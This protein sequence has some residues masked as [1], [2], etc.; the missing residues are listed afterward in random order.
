MNSD[1]P[2]RLVAPE[3]QDGESQDLSLRPTRLS[4]YI[5]QSTVKENLRVF[6]HAARKRGQALDHVLLSGPPGLGKT[7]L[8]NIFANELAVPLR[9]SSGPVVERQG[10]L[11]AIL[12][13]LEPGSVLFL[14]EIHRMNRVVEEVLYSAMEDFT[15]DILIGEGP[16]ARTVKLDLPRFTLVGAT[17]RAGLLSAPLRDR[18]GIQCRLEYYTPE[19]LKLIVIRAAA[20]LEIEIVEEAAMELATR[21]RGT[22]RIANRMLRRCRDFADLE[23]GGVITL[24][25]VQKSLARM[26]ID[27]L[28]LD[29][30]DCHILRTIIEKYDGGPVGLNTLSAAVSEEQDTLE[31]VY[32]PFLL[33]QGFLQRT[34]RGRMVT[35]Q[36]YEHLGMNIRSEDQLPLFSN[37]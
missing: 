36:A 2:D 21:S 24:P 4:E 31:E 6:I 3:I 34:P 30:M 18:F 33:M 25:L 16:A 26:G 29:Q 19:E 17:T 37:R 9:S 10:D 14:D 22:P 15:L 5:A 13:N 1:N 32:E 12:T 23:T 35:R 28:G 8:A 11:A 7:T 20:L 27:E